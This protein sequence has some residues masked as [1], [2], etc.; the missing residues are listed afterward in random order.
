VST[1]GAGEIDAWLA[2]VRDQMT[3]DE[4]VTFVRRV[5]AADLHADWR[6]I[7]REVMGLPATADAGR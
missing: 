6:V 4:Y 3:T 1:Y 7:L 2:P 5:R